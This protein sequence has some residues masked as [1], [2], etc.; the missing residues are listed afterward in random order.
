MN[1]VAVL[2]WPVPALPDDLVTRRI[3]Y[4]PAAPLLA[5]YTAQAAAFRAGETTPRAFLEQRLETIDAAEPAVRAFVL[6]DQE[7]APGVGRRG[8]RALEG[9]AAVGAGGRHAGRD[10]GHDRDARPADL[11]E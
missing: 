10:Q 3:R 8:N 1:D 4:D 6:L 7:G 9:R 2:P 11:D 5:P